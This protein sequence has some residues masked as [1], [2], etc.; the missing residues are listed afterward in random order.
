MSTRKNSKLIKKKIISKTNTV[1]NDESVDGSIDS[2]DTKI[3]QSSFNAS[4]NADKKELGT[5]IDN[6][7]IKLQKEG[8]SMSDEE[9]SKLSN[10]ISKLK[11]EYLDTSISIANEERDLQ[12][13]NILEVKRLSEEHLLEIISLN[14]EPGKKLSEDPAFV[15]WYESKKLWLRKS[16]EAIPAVDTSKDIFKVGN[17][18]N[19]PLPKN[20]KKNMDGRL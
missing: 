7:D 8:S 6:L 16:K 12:N 19:K 20:L 17:R 2:V 5:M 11:K 15:C 9:R 13:K 1:H 18:G 14:I 3:I 10:L 4:K